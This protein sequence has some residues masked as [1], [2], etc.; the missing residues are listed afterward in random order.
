MIIYISGIYIN[1]TCIECLWFSMIMHSFLEGI[2][3]F[4]MSLQNRLR[5]NS[6]FFIT[7]TSTV[8]N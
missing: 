8:R 6:L 4:E 2:R 3:L 5:E 1:K 7:V